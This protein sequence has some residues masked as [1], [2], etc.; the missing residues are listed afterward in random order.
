MADGGGEFS[1][2]RGNHARTDIEI[3]FSISIGPV[4]TKF[5]KQIHLDY[6]SQIILIKQKLVALLRQDHVTN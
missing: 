4:T 6:L 2:L 3:D 1:F 5:G